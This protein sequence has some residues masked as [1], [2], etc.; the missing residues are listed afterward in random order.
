MLNLALTFLTLTASASEALDTE[1]SR[2]DEE[3]RLASLDQSVYPESP[4]TSADQLPATIEVETCSQAFNDYYYFALVDGR[5]WYKP[6]F[7]RPAKSPEW[8]TDLEWKPFGLDGG[9]PYRLANEDPMDLDTTFADGM[10][11]DFVEGLHF[12]TATQIE[13]PSYLDRSLWEEAGTWPHEEALELDPSF[14]T[15]DRVLCITADDDEIAVL[16]DNRQMFY[17]RKVANLFV[18]TEWYEG[19]GQAKELTVWF[20][21]HLTGHRG[22]SIGRITA[23]GAGY[24]SGP[25]GR[26]FEWGPAA[27]S[28]ETMVW[29]SPNGRV[30]YYLDSGTPPVVEHFVEAPFR[31]RWRG[32]GIDSS[33]ST[34]MLIDRFGAVYTKIADFDLLGSTPTHPYCYFEECDDEVFYPPG[35]IRSGMSDIRLPS[36]GWTIHDPILPPE[37][38]DEGTWLSNRVTIVQTGKGNQAR[39]LRVLGRR[40]GELGTYYKG[41]ADEV[42]LFRAAPAKDRGFEGLE[43]LPELTRYTSVRVLEELHWGEPKLDRELVGLVE[44]EGQTLGF[45]VLDFNPMASPWHVEVSAGDV[46]VPLELHVVQAWNKFMTPEAGRAEAR[47]MTWETT[48]AFDFATVMR[49]MGGAAGTVQGVALRRLLESAKN[50]RFGLLVNSTGQGLELTVKKERK[51]GAIHAVALL[52]EEA[53]PEGAEGAATLDA[54]SERF[55]AQQDDQMGWVDELAA[56][57]PPP[58]TCNADGLAWAARVLE[59]DRRS[60]EDLHAVRATKR[61]A[62][63]FTRFTRATSGFLYLSQLKTI[64]AALDA[65]RQ[66]RGNEVR[67]N[68]LRFNVITGITGRI[69]FLSENIWHLNRRRLGALKAER[70]ELEEGLAPLLQAI[71]DIGC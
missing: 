12:L 35:D 63:G 32:E 17:R 15:I 8:R 31:G 20:P 25:D 45:R 27:V 41:I 54:L 6:R 4:Y 42:W 53:L 28:M 67:P 19:W 69:P 61:D 22:W 3:R 9:L 34:I 33:A 43:P 23:F 11:G 24:K 71:E 39:E 50:N 52:P 55:W 59:L 21:D 18:N 1:L 60:Q 44:V 70:E 47:V 68:E 14:P 58:E 5:I 13:A 46:H 10:R 65:T 49:A 26:I 37:A 40:E 30:I 57:G 7:K 62:R 66:A 38:W 29:L 48:L 16:G 36:E 64:D 56:L 51:T 2:L